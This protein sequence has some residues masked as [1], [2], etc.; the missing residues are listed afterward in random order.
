MDVEVLS[1]L[2]SAGSALLIMT[3]VG[4]AIL[5]RRRNMPFPPSVREME[6]ARQRSKQTG[7]QSQAQQQQQHQQHQHQQPTQASPH[8][9]VMSA[10][11]DEGSDDPIVTTPNGSPGGGPSSR[12]PPPVKHASEHP[13]QASGNSSPKPSAKPARF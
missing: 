12:A 9:Q 8:I 6:E 3:I 1:I 11:E 7:Q 4:V 2:L 5:I 10:D 13:A